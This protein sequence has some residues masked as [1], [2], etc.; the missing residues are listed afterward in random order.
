MAS[1]AAKVLGRWRGEWPYGGSVEVRLFGQLEAVQEGVAVPVQGAKQRA[2][3]ALLA[4]QRGQPVSADRLIDALWGDGRAA[5]PANALQAQ[6]GQLRRTFGA[7]AIVTTEAGYA[8]AVGPD[9][10]DVVRF[11]Q[12]VAKGRRLA[13]DDEM[14]PA[15]AVLGEALGLRRGEPLAEFTYAGFFDAERAHLGELTLV[16]I[17]ARAGADLRLGRHGELAGELEARCREHP[18][19]EGLWELLILAL[20]RAGRQAE[21]LRAYTEIRDRLVSELGIDPGAALRE[22]QARILAQDPSLAPAST[23]GPAPVRAA[24][25]TAAGNLRER[26]STFVGRDAELEQLLGSVRS[27][28]LVTLTGPGGTGKTR[29]AVEAAAALRAEYQDGAWLVELASVAAPDGVGPAVAGALGAVASALGSPQP[30]GSAVQ[31]IVRHLAGRSLVVVLDNCEHVIAEAAALAD[32]LAGA[33]PGLRLIATSREALGIPG[34]VLVPVGGLAIPAA[35]ELFADR[36]QAVRPGFLADGQAGDVIEDICRRLD[37]LPLAVELA[38][39][40]LRALPL[41]TVAERLDDRFRLLTGGARTALPRQQT[42]R[43]VVD[44]SYDLLFE[45]ER[46]LFARL[47][48]FTGGCDLTAAEAICADDQ[49]PAGEILDVLSR[50]VDK[51]L[52]TAPGAAGEARFTQLQTLWQYGRDRLEDSGEADAMRARHAAYYLQIAGE[53]HSGLR[54]VTGPVWRDRLASESG[55]LRA[56][57][58]WHIATGDADAALSLASGMAWLWFI[59]GDFVEGARWLGAALGAKGQRQS[60][61]WERPPTSG[62][63]IAWACRPA[64]RQASL[65][66]RRLSPP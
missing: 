21:A 59:D 51:S 20:Y 17:E 10:V 5:N 16:A 25:P 48:V 15:S 14:A 19:R 38:A 6:I 13:A 31:L 66:V 44:W 61:R 56:A 32:T 50:L 26:L 37:G 4:L 33:V 3:L 36:A 8:L 52:V 46:R 43:A 62:T 9:E 34:E 57:L 55:N 64:R 12:L 22:L 27:S 39:A 45:D 40:R 28:R 18:L 42:L 49:V 23:A 2:L 60:P 65:N 58:D 30:P 29:L 41:A 24:A 35:V 63:A 11:E 1:A 53:A 47:A 54:G 7:A